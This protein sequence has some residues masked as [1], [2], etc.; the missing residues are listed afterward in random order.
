MEQTQ[1]QPF[2]RPRT[3]RVITGVT[4]ALANRTGIDRLWIRAGFVVLTFVGGLGLVAY[5]LATAAIRSEGEQTNPFQSWIVRFDQTETTGQKVG[6]WLLSTLMLAAI[7]AV[8][9]FQGPFVVLGL[10]GLGAWLLV[11][12]TSVGQASA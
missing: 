9:L 10:M 2:V 12:P 8:S 6:W 11:R 5:A 3:G 7:A 4:S 1:T